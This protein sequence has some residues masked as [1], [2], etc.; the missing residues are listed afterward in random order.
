MWLPVRPAQVVD[1]LDGSEADGTV[2]FELDSAEHEIDLNTGHARQLREALA[3]YIVT[4]RRARGSTASSAR[5]AR[6]IPAARARHH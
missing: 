3:P 2:R 4:A 1:D 6:K 5:G